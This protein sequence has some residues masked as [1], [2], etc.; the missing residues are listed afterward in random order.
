[1]TTK[2]AWTE[3]HDKGMTKFTFDDERR[4]LHIAVLQVPR[5]WSPFSWYASLRGQPVGQGASATLDDAG[6][7]AIAES[8]R[9]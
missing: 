3:S 1:M 6:D 2:L 9:P 8:E 7:A 4:G 5:E